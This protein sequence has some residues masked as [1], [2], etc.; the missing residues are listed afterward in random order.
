M[1][2]PWE[3]DIDWG[4][5][6]TTLGNENDM[7]TTDKVTV[8]E[9]APYIGKTTTD[10]KEND[11]VIKATESRFNQTVQK[12]QATLIA[13]LISRVTSLEDTVEFILEQLEIDD[14]T[15]E[16]WYDWREEQEYEDRWGGITDD[17]ME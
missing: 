14:E 10:Y 3:D 9:F 7:V 15:D 12:D 5:I 1:K 13:E 6:A 16:E 8:T 4:N 11:M 17:N 2:M